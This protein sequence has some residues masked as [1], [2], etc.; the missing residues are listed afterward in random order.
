M[1][2]S[3]KQHLIDQLHTVFEKNR[4]VLLLDFYRYQRSR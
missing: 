2:K 3:E 4:A 1:L